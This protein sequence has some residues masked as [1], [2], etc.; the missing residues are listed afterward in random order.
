MAD[1][2]EGMAQLQA[3]L[4]RIKAATQNLQPALL[5][6]GLVVLKSAQDR[7]DAGGPGW[8]PNKTHTPLLHRTG[9]LLASL[10]VGAGGN[11][12]SVQGN[13]IVV[14]TNVSY[15]PYLQ[16][17]TRGRPAKHREGRLAAMLGGAGFFKHE[18]ALVGAIPP[19]VFLEIDQQAVERINSILKNYI[20]G[21][22]LG[23]S[24]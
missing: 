15:A 21:N 4:G 9:R 5:R 20:M 7:I 16:F 8:P 14:G 18:G 6:A 19:R 1:G 17:G 10:M 3:R 12:A 2:I 24:E 23:A 13:S 11:V 22:G